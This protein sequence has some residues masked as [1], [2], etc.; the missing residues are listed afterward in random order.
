MKGEGAFGLH[1]ASEYSLKPFVEKKLRR[2]TNLSYK[3]YLGPHVRLKIRVCLDSSPIK[4]EQNAEKVPKSCD[5][6]A[7][8]WLMTVILIQNLL[9]AATIT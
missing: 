2:N 1:L 4:N 5:L 9:S 8:L 3:V 6:G 7:F